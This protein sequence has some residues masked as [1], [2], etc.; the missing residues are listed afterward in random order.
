MKK[1]AVVWKPI[2]CIDQQGIF[3]FGA[4]I[5]KVFS[6]EYERILKIVFLVDKTSWLPW[7]LPPRRSE[8]WVVRSNPAGV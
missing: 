8:P 3:T 6:R 2:R 5:N 1:Q 4:L 7:R